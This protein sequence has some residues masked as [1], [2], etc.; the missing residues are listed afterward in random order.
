ME[1]AGI[2]SH[3][4]NTGQLCSKAIIPIWTRAAL[5]QV[6][7]PCEISGRILGSG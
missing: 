7:M 6:D 2:I 1:G 4:T 5:D 3:L